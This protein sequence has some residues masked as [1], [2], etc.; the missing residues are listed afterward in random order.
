MMPDI[1]ITISVITPSV[2][3]L[4]TPNKRQ[5]LTKW[6]GKKSKDDPTTQE[7]HW[8]KRHIAWKWK[9]EM[10]EYILFKY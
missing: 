3:E 8:M 4:N 7:I 2:N 9:K 10:K 6:G 5:R 1:S